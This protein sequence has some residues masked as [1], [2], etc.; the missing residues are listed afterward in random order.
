MV[1]ARLEKQD[2]EQISDLLYNPPESKPYQAIKE[3]LITAYEESDNRQFQKLLSEMEL[4]DQKP[5]H[6]LRRMR[7]LARDRIPDATLRILW[8]NHLPP[9]IRSVLAV[10][11]SFSTKTALE[12]LALLA[13]KMLEQHREVAAVSTTLPPPTSASQNIDT[14][15]LINEIRK[16]SI[17]IAQLKSRQP[18][19]NFRRNRSRSRSYNPRYKSR[20]RDNTPSKAVGKLERTLAEAESGAQEYSYRLFVTDK[21]T[22]ISFLVDTGANISV[23]PRKKTH[24]TTPLPFKLYAANNTT[25][26]TYGEKTLEL[27]LSLRRPYKWKFIVADVS[28]PILGADFLKHHQLIVDLKNKKL[29]DNVTNLTVKAPVRAT[30]IPTVRSIDSNNIYHDILSEFPGITRLTAM[31]INDSKINVQHYIETEGPPVHCRAR[32]IPPHR[33]EQVRK[34]FQNMMEQG[35][36]RPSKSP[37]ASPLHVVPK[38]NGDIRVCGDY[39]RLNAI[40]KADRYPV[41]SVKDFTY[42]L[43]GKTIFSTID[44]NRAYQQLCVREEDI[45]KTAIITP[46]GLFEF[47]RMCPGLKNAGQ[48]FQRFIHQVL[49]GLPYV[50]PFIDDVLLASENEDLHR[51]H[52]RT[53]LRR[54]EEHGI[55]INP[56]K[57]HFGQTEVQFLGYHVS[58]DGIKPP[59]QKIDIIMKYPKPTNIEELRRFLGMLN[60]YRDH[61]PNAASIQAPLNAYLHNVKKRDKT[62]IQWTEESTQAFEACKNSISNAALLAHPSHQATYA[63]FCDASDKSAG[64]VLQQYVNKSWQP[65]GYYSKKFSDA[66]SRYSTYDRELQAIYMAVKHFRK[67]FEGRPLIIFTDHK[68][69]TFAMNKVNSTT[70]TP[71]QRFQHIHVDIVGPLPTTTQGYRYLITMIDRETKW[72]EAIPTDDITAETVAEAI[73]KHWIVRFGCPS[74]LTSDQGRQFESQLFNNLMKIMGITKNRTTPYHPHSNGIVERW[75][76]TLKAALRTKLSSTRSWIDE[77]PTVLLGLRATLRTD[78]EV[79]PAELTY[80]YNL[81]LPGDFFTTSIPTTTDDYTYVNKIRKAI[82]QNRPQAATTHHNS[83][84]SIFIHKDLR[85][86]SHV[87]VRVDAIKKP[88]QP[89]YEGPYRVIKRTEKVYT[90]QLQNRETN[91]SID[92]LKPA[93]LLQENIPND[94]SLQNSTSPQNTSDKPHGSVTSQPTANNNKV[95]TR[96]GRSVKLPHSTPCKRMHQQSHAQI[97]TEVFKLTC[98]Y[99]SCTS[100]RST[101]TPPPSEVHAR[102]PFAAP[103]AAEK[104]ETRERFTLNS[105]AA[106]EE[107]WAT[108]V[109]KGKG[110]GKGKSSTPAPAPATKSAAKPTTASSAK[111][112]AKSTAKTSAKS[113]AMPSGKPAAKATYKP[114]LKTPKTAAVVLQLQPEAVERGLTYSSVLRTAQEKVDLQ[115][116]GIDQIRSR[117]TATGAR[118]LEISGSE[119]NAKADRLAESLRGA[120]S[121]VVNIVRPVKSAEVRISGLD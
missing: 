85:N 7:D 112:A 46:M 23:L 45:E 105:T 13:D 17:E 47:P 100:S 117:Q 81:R 18:Q 38:K 90:I 11:D 49:S 73:Y 114:K 106:Q 50:F 26:S 58:K 61:I 6:L 76:R 36:C 3:R 72:P 87:F 108:V 30:T 64:A 40:T 48:T 79:S 82:E 57:C 98:T 9:H 89:P 53:V 44:L 29:I 94:T 12:E 93:Y 14:N 71:R 65:L 63:L 119:R 35:L 37:W 39:R 92:R 24:F 118:M 99:S 28:K 15:F 75:H 1:I 69:L 86:C 32:P 5:S 88:L 95:T 56:S 103:I 55:T 59:A 107:T 77:L 66:Q 42:Q 116:L 80:G 60:F 104:G 96:A 121:G 10:S 19:H 109:R 21:K 83:K 120:L 54:L 111:Q 22:G 110:K 101:I 33:Y 70:E 84:Q 67:M 74:T 68:P 16:L 51:E 27:D 102:D 31:N 78:A 115:E 25:I 113:T 2:I 62:I 34:E 52:L 8:T 97:F 41:P 20:S 43:A 4:G 91:I